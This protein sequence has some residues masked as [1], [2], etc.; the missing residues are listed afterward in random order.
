[1]LVEKLI[2]KIKLVENVLVRYQIPKDDNEKAIKKLLEDE[3]DE[4]H[5]TRQILTIKS[6]IIAPKK[7]IEN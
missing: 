3:L 7:F 2:D 5:F 6:S 1:M 4:L